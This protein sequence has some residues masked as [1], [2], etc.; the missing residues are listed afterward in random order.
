[1]VVYINFILRDIM[2]TEL[3]VDNQLS[4][5]NLNS[6]AINCVV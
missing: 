3:V 6:T 1:M 2:M 4:L 5:I